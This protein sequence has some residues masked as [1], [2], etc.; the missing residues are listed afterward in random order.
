MPPLRISV[1][2]YLNTAPLVWGFTRGPLRGKYDLRF[3]VPSECAEQLRRG[4]VDVGIIPVIEYQRMDGMVFLPGCAVAAKDFVRSI[5]LLARR[6]IEQ[7]R[8]IALDVSSRSSQTLVRILCRERWRIEPDFVPAK[9]DAAAML[10]DADAAL[11]IGDPAL[12]ISVATHSGGEFPIPGVE[13]L[14]IYDVAHEWREFTGLPC[15]LAAWVARREAVTPQLVADFIESKNYGVARIAEIAED[16][17]PK[18]K[19]PVAA[20][21]S[22]LRDNI[23][24]GLDDANLRGLELYFRKA[25]ETG[26]IDRARPVEFAASG[27][28]FR[29]RV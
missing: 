21:E 17:A 10:A 8:R 3:A 16:A 2:E 20:L 25:A 15:V 11:I 24:Y 5:L 26:V 7:A 14:Y 9:P 29:L 12:R 18:L 22:Y 23:D 19:M 4:D 13:T 6:P 1:V 28:A 27:A